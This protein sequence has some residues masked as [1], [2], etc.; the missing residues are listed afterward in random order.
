MVRNE[1]IEKTP[2]WARNGEKIKLSRNYFKATLLKLAALSFVRWEKKGKK[3][4]TAVLE[5]T[6]ME[7]STLGDVKGKR[8]ISNC[9]NT[10]KWMPHRWCGKSLD[11]YKI[12]EPTSTLIVSTIKRL[13]MHKIE[14]LFPSILYT[15]GGSSQGFWFSKR[16]ILKE[17]I[18]N[19]KEQRRTLV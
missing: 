6:F 15:F 9:C 4:N 8:N 5:L 12:E 10:D 11:N 13:I 19:S 7:A 18:E 2:N 16:G 3:H 14:E 17:K 1:W